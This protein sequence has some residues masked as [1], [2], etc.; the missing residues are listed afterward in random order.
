MVQSA[1]GGG[2]IMGAKVTELYCVQ[3]ML[4]SFNILVAWKLDYL[5]GFSV[6]L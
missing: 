6:T 1:N 2:G 5:T 4:V 3:V